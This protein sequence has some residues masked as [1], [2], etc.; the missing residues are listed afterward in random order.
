MQTF[1][2]KAPRFPRGKLLPLVN[3]L[4]VPRNAGVPLAPVTGDTSTS[5][6][7]YNTVVVN[8]LY[9]I[10]LGCVWVS[11]KIGDRVKS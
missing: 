6:N 8:R 9:V 4:W 10:L 3:S 1:F 11:E 2:W 7:I 5:I